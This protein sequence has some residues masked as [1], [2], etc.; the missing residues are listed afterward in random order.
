[1]QQ[2]ATDRRQRILDAALDVFSVKGYRDTAVDDIAHRSETSKGG[3]Y[4]H[5]PGKD[6]I[7]LALLDRTADRLAAK[8]EG[9]A[10]GQ[11]DAIG[12]ADAALRAVIT[13]FSTH[14]SLARLLMVEALG[15]GR[16]FHQR[17]ARIRDDF[18]AVVTRHLDQAVAEGTIPAVDTEVAGRAWFGAVNEL[19]TQWV[20]SEDP[21]SLD[22]I[23]AALVPLLLRS[24][25]L[26]EPR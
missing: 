5:F 26:P 1:M 23:Y 13:T 9:A 6:A 25:G 12:R 21:R 11:D 15:A 24:V 10:A 7:F 2:R 4:F 18:A 22:E 20:L 16:E 17:M 19:V 14:R 8:I 3:V